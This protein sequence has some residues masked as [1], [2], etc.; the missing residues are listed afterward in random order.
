MSNTF[1]DFDRECLES[2]CAH[3]GEAD[4][5]LGAYLDGNPTVK[6]TKELALEVALSAHYAEAFIKLAKQLEEEKPELF[7]DKDKYLSIAAKF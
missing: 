5:I 7:E 4:D 1:D 3:L 6:M 2:L